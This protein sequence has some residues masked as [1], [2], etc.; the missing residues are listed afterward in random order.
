MSGKFW[1]E[2]PTVFTIAGRV[3]T[4]YNKHVNTE[5]LHFTADDLLQRFSPQQIDRI[6]QRSAGVHVQSRVLTGR[7]LVAFHR[8]G[9][10]WCAGVSGWL[11][12]AIEVLGY[13]AHEARDQYSVAQ[14]LEKLPLLSRAAEN[15]TIR[16]SHLLAVVAH[17]TP[18]TEER[19]LELARSCSI[20]KLRKILRGGQPDE[21]TD[22][23]E[24]RLQVDRVLAAVLDQVTRQLSEEAGRPL[25][26]AE[27]IHCLCAQRLTG[28]A[29]PDERVWA[30]ATREAQRDCESREVASGKHW[31]TVDV[32][33]NARLR[34]NEEARLLT[35][36]QRR[37][38][39]RRD[40]YCC[41]TPG[42]PN[43]LWLHAHH[44]RFFCAGGATDREN[45][46]IVCSRCHRNIHEGHLRV[47]GR[48][49]N[50]L[51]W[52]DRDG[53]PYER[54]RL[55]EPGGWFQQWWGAAKRAPPQTTGDKCAGECVAA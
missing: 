25:K 4:S 24:L 23:A 44:I 31:L 38:L 36:A 53:S 6:A 18:E 43:T 42:C 27:V 22:T 35:P 1:S 40:G 45:M 41:S 8:G 51:H 30:S 13:T 52:T 3:F 48:A 55:P 14:R 32:L 12:Y 2:S 50:R 28:S 37:E 10:G 20:G 47:S 5:I 49:P 15:G 19:C 46:L 29:F 7:C 33:R 16:W 54:R 34:F 17:A 21:D 26:T 9:L 39:L 11:H